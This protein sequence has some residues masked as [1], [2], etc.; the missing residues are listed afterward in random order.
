MAPSHL[1]SP[2]PLLSYLPLPGSHT[3]PLP[4]RR[5]LFLPPSATP[6]GD[7]APPPARRSSHP[8]K[9]SGEGEW[10]RKAVPPG[11]AGPPAPSPRSRCRRPGGRPCG[12]RALRGGRPCHWCP[13]LLNLLVLIFGDH[14]SF[15]G[16]YSWSRNTCIYM[17]WSMFIS[18]RGWYSGVKWFSTMCKSTIYIIE[19]ISRKMKKEN[20][21]ALVVC[22][23]VVVA[24]VLAVSFIVKCFLQNVVPWT[25]KSRT[26]TELFSM[27]S[28]FPWLAILYTGIIATTFC[29]WAEIVAMRDVS[30]TETAIIYGLEP[31]WGATFA[32]AIHG[33]RWDITGLIGA[34]FIIAGSLMVQVLGSFL[35]IDVSEDSYQM[36]S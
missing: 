30:A 8:D 18:S 6:S 4:R 12:R 35:D 13:A 10:W 1:R 36:N 33:E 32:W 2:F 27:M 34:V 11:R 16:W 15:L 19:H 3:T 22:Q 14:C 9:A 31:V 29:L 25:L 23:V 7:T 5:H 17:T 28:S 26:P 24:V 20:F 21:L